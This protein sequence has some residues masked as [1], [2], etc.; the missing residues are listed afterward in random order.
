[1]IG[2]QQIMIILLV[3]VLLFGASKLP[4]IGEGMGKAIRNFKKGMKDIDTDVEDITPAPK[5]DKQEETA[6]KD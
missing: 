2:T 1:M 6:K 3:V 4:Q 5:L